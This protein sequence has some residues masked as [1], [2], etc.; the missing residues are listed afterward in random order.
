MKSAHLQET[1]RTGMVMGRQI[2]VSAF[3]SCSC[4]DL[5]KDSTALI[6]LFSPPCGTEKNC[7]TDGTIENECPQI[8]SQ[9]PPHRGTAQLC[10]EVLGV[11]ERSVSISL[12]PS[13]PCNAAFVKR[14]PYPK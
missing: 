9:L 1:V 12:E 7:M 14:L 11:S 13:R 4:K 8:L 2:L 10:L 5:R 6:K 3:C